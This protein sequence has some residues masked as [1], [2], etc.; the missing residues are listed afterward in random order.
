ME[1]RYRRATVAIMPRMKDRMLRGELYVASDPEILADLHRAS[2]LIDRYNRTLTEEHDER[3][4]LLRELLAA[5][6]EDVVV[7][8]PFYCDYGRYI[9]IGDRTF[10]NY[11]C[12]MLDGATLEIGADCQI[13][14]RVQLVTATHPLEAQPR[15]D[16]WES[17]EPVV[18]GDNVWL[19]AGVIVCPGVTIGDD[20]VVAAGGVVT[21]DLPAG[22]L[23]AGVPATVKREI[24]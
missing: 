15:R 19:G 12:V 2:A 17:V 23:A 11:D 21:K 22:V 24:A 13:A 16:K 8:P 3:D 20:T 7:R 1:Q 5:V 6:G 4:R 18:I 9:S 14:P 10:I